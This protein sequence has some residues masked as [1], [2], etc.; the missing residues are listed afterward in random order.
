M[1]IIEGRVLAL[2]MKALDRYGRIQ[3]GFLAFF[4]FVLTGILVFLVILTYPIGFVAERVG[5]GHLV[6]HYA[7]WMI[8]L[9]IMVS[10]VCWLKCVI[11]RVNNYPG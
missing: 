10:L 3:S 1:S 8:N 11:S 9:G 5:D 4:V 2:H 7:R 6:V